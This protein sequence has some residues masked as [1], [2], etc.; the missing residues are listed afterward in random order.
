MTKSPI[1]DLEEYKI[2]ASILLKKFRSA[3]QKQALHSAQRLQKL[4]RL[5]DT[6]VEEIVRLNGKIKRKHTLQVIAIE[7]GF[8]TWVE[9]KQHIEQRP[10]KLY[11]KHSLYT[12]LYPRRCQGFLNQWFVQYDEARAYLDENGGYLFP[13]KDEFFICQA[14]Y[15]QALG[16]DPQDR[17]WGQIAFDWVQPANQTAWQRLNSQLKNLPEK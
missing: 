2:Q 12:A 8:A 10:E 5:A 7:N 17:D 14:G 13:Y 6:S 9:L 15:I 4:P 16:L 3:D 1:Y 11:I